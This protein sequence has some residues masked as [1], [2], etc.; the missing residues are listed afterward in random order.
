MFVSYV[1]GIF[2]DSVV[3]VDGLI[4]VDG[5]TDKFSLKIINLPINAEVTL[6]RQ[7]PLINEISI[8]DWVL[9][10]LTIASI[11]ILAQNIQI[12]C[13]KREIGFRNILKGD[14]IFI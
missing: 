14:H 6:G 13:S 12:L 4:N 10:E 3:D 7:R 9:V 2:C 5:K 11:W 8:A 1:C